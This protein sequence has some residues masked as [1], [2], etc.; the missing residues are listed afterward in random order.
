[1]T[2]VL[3]SATP[4]DIVLKLNRAVAATLKEPDLKKRLTQISVIPVD[5][6]SPEAVA[7]ALRGERERWRGFVKELD[8]QP[9]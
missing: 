8:V 6:A 2:L 7:E 1:M 9:E 4:M 3:P 5:G